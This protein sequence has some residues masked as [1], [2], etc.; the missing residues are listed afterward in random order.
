MVHNG[1]LEHKLLIQNPHLQDPAACTALP[2]CTRSNGV[3]GEWMLSCTL[4]Q[5]L[6]DPHMIAGFREH[7][8]YQVHHKYIFFLAAIAAI[9]VGSTLKNQFRFCSLMVYDSSISPSDSKHPSGN[10]AIDVQ[11]NSKPRLSALQ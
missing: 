4:A 8:S 5:S 3:E 10:P 2:V 1:A 9:V 7:S 6:K 11:D